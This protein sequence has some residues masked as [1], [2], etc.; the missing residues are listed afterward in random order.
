[1]MRRAASATAAIVLCANA[2]MP[3]ALAHESGHGAAFWPDAMTRVGDSCSAAEPWEINAPQTSGGA[4][5]GLQNHLWASG[6]YGV[7]VVANKNEV[8]GAWGPNS[9]Q[10]LANYQSLFG[11][12][13]DSCAGY[14]V[15]GHLQGWLINA[16]NYTHYAPNSGSAQATVVQR[17]E[18]RNDAAAF[19]GGFSTKIIT[20]AKETSGDR[21]GCHWFSDIGSTGWRTWAPSGLD[22]S[23]CTLDNAQGGH[24]W[25]TPLFV[26]PAFSGSF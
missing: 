9:E 16:G 13:I 10:A 14:D 21:F 24:N 17:I 5:R 8:D 1:M 25:N 3:H 18:F 22:S 20:Q 4:V 12:P 2:Q 23:E 26:N 19:L 6:G 15:Y 11:L 7:P